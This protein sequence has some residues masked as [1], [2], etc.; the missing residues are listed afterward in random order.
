MANPSVITDYQIA[1]LADGLA[2]MV[3][4]DSLGIP[5]PHPVWVDAVSTAKLGD[6]SARF[7]GLPWLRWDWGFV[8]F[9]QRDTL[10]TF[11]TG[12][13]A[14]VYI[15]TPT[16][17]RISGVSNAAQAYLCKMWWPSPEKPEDPQ[18]GRR[19]EFSISFKQMVLQTWP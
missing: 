17:N 5:K 8:T 7:L 11:C 4:L 15:V 19:L 6:G 1:S 18:T 16:T 10:R 14:S 9:S 2:G 3:T 13:S 12:A